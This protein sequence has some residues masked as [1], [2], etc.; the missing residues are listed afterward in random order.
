MPIQENQYDANGLAQLAGNRAASLNLPLHAVDV[1]YQGLLERSKL[2]EQYQGLQT[3]LQEQQLRNQGLF[4]VQQLSNQG[5]LAQTQLQGQNQL[6]NTALTGQN[7]LANTKQEG[8]N[9]LANTGAMVQGYYQ[10][11]VQNQTQQIQNEAQAAQLQHQVGMA[12]AA[13]AQ[14]GANANLMQAQ[15]DNQWKDLQARIEMNR[16]Q[17]QQRG[18]AGASF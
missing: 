14:T 9:T 15:T 8:V 3:Q 5:Q 4:G 16:Y 11:L 17:L 6:A 13:A 7:Q 1:G 2:Q 10:P 18:A 12:Q